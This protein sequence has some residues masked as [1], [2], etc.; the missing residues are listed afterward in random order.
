MRFAR[1]VSLVDVVVAIMALFIVLLPP[2]KMRAVW[3]A[4][5]ESERYALALAEARVLDDQQRPTR[6]G[7][8]VSELAR[9]LGKAGFHDWAVEAGARGAVATDRSPSQWRALLATSVAYVDRLDAKPGL[10]YARRAL[11]ACAA[12]RAVDERVCPAWEEVRMDFYTRHLQA[13][14]DSGIDAH[15]DPHG[16]RRA[17]EAALRTIRAREVTPR[18]PATGAG[19]AASAGSAAGAG[20]ATP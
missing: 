10:D 19:S 4:S 16:F 15:K 8:L 14:V 17:G 12:A 13:G 2:R 9:R 18:T 5:V 6:D 11:A 20:S 3:A 7:T 1:Y